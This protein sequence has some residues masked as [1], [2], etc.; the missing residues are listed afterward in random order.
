VA[1][2]FDAAEQF[3]EVR[4]GR[5]VLHFRDDI[6][7]SPSRPNK[8]VVKVE[9]VKLDLFIFV[10]PHTPFRVARTSFMLDH[11][12]QKPTF[13]AMSIIEANQYYDRDLEQF[14]TEL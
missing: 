10:N 2:S 7:N 11:D 14:T 12:S 4:F 3:V 5:V 9:D 13:A 1:T 6:R 8:F